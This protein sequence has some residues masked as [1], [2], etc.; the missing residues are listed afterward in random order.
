M[1]SLIAKIEQEAA[2]AS[3]VGRKK[4]LDTLR[5]LQY[6]IET[7][8]DA[9]QRVIHMVCFPSRRNYSELCTCRGFPP[10][11]QTFESVIPPLLQTFESV[12]YPARYYPRS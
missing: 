3:Y 11:L 8:E 5:D 10:L 6:S 2:S 1:E 4:L 7:P 12:V 9:M